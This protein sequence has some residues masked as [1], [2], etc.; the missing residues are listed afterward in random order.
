M[1]AD[2]FKKRLNEYVQRQLQTVDFRKISAEG[3]SCCVED[4]VTKYR[5]MSPEQR[6]AAER[7]LTFNY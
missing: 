4:I 7:M 3:I 5:S 1:P 2:D 6:E